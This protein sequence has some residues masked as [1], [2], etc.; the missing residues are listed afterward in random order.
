[1][2]FFFFIIGLEIKRE[3][4]VGELANIKPKTALTVTASI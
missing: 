1:M 2:T 4:L 3:I